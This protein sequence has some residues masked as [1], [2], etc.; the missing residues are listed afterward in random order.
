MTF[1]RINS[2]T[3]MSSQSI[4][5]TIYTQCARVCVRVFDLDCTLVSCLF[6]WIAAQLWGEGGLTQNEGKVSSRLATTLY[7][8]SLILK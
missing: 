2:G 6:S 8:D 4:Y 1:A 5:T 7:T 3:M